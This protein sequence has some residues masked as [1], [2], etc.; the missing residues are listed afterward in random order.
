MFI[1]P[2][3]GYLFFVFANTAVCVSLRVGGV[4]NYEIEYS[5]GRRDE[6]IRRHISD[7]PITCE[8]FLVE[9]LEKGRKI[10]AIYHGG[11]PVSQ[12]MFDRMVKSAAG[13]LAQ[14]HVCKSI[15]CDSVEAH[16]R[17]GVPA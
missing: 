10:H 3:R 16:Y 7:D 8:N 4:M 1:V 6:Q 2:I 13:M 5:S 14:N 12:G 11:K 17:F 15:G 9:L